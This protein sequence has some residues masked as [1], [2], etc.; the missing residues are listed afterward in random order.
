MWLVRYLRFKWVCLKWF[1][2]SP[3]KYGDPALGEGELRKENR[4][5]LSQ[6]YWDRKPKP[7]DFG[8]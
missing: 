6:R 7:E 4:K 8:L 3:Y 2:G 5:I 1:F